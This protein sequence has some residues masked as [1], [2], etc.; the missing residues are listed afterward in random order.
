MKQ[1]TTLDLSYLTRLRQQLDTTTILSTLCYRS[2][3]LGNAMSASVPSFE[4]SP[5]VQEYAISE[6]DYLSQH[7]DVHIICT[8]A[9]VFN[10]QGR[11]LLVQRAKEETAFPNVW[12]SFIG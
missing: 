11:M 8:G 2:L 9:V 12:V 7:K 10:R 1:A 5:S 6:G 3:F 4:Y